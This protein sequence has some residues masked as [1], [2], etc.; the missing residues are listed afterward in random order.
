MNK[1]QIKAIMYFDKC[2]PQ[3][4]TILPRIEKELISKFNTILNNLLYVS[5]E[6]IKTMEK[7]GNSCRT[8]NMYFDSFLDLCINQRDGQCCMILTK[9]KENNNYVSSTTGKHSYVINCQSEGLQFSTIAWNAHDV[10]ANIIPNL[11]NQPIIIY[12]ALFKTRPLKRHLMVKAITFIC[13]GFCDDTIRYLTTGKLKC[14]KTRTTADIVN[15]WWKERQENHG[16]LNT[17]NDGFFYN[18]INVPVYDSINLAKKITEEQG[19]KSFGKVILGPNEYSNLSNISYSFTRYCKCGITKDSLDYHCFQCGSAANIWLDGTGTL[20]HKLEGC[21]FENGVAITKSAYIAMYKM[22]NKARYA[23]DTLAATRNMIQRIERGEMTFVDTEEGN[24]IAGL[25]QI[26]VDKMTNK[27]IMEVEV[28]YRAGLNGY[29]QIKIINVTTHVSNVNNNIKE[30]LDNQNMNET[31]NNAQ[32]N[33][34]IRQL[35]PTT[36][37]KLLNG[38]NEDNKMDE[39]NKDNEMDE[40]NTASNHKRLHMDED[41]NNTIYQPRKRRKISHTTSKIVLK[42]DQCDGDILSECN[43]QVTSESNL[44]NNQPQPTKIDVVIK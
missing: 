18:K 41:C 34:N 28:K 37:N 21:I 27:F 43:N 14:N 30:N 15:Y 12:D 10:P 13:H 17:N 8:T 6:K 20:S 5:I 25:I 26:F 35:N 4:I 29:H 44:K 23:L 22:L 24:N 9:V 42:N 3:E 11:N 1:L 39:D 38:D 16:I 7:W 40:D 2:F 19:D 33:D 31:T 32:S 36:Q